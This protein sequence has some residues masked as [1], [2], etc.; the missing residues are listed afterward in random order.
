VTPSVVLDAVGE[1]SPTLDAY[2]HGWLPAVLPAAV[3]RVRV[4]D[5]ILASTLAD[6]GAELVD[7]APDVEIAPA[8]ELRGDA[9]LAVVTFDAPP[10]DSARLAVRLGRRLLRSARVRIEG[11]RAR[12]AVQSRGYPRADLVFWDVRQTFREPDL[13]AGSRSLVEYLPQRAL[14]LG[15]RATAAPT[16][17]EACL[18]DAAG[19]LGA[20]LRSEPPSIR[21]GLLTAVTDRGVLR[22]AV[23]PARGQIDAQVAALEALRRL[24]PPPEIDERVPWT[25]ADGRTGLARWSLE[26]RLAGT[27]PAA[28][29][30]P[31]LLARCVDFLVALQSCRGGKGGSLREAAATVARA[32]PSARSLPA[33]GERLDTV[34]AEVPRGFGHGDFFLGNLLLDERGA[35]SG[36]VDWD[37]AGSNRLPLIDLIHLRHM[38]EYSLPDEEWGPTLVRS[39]LPWARAGGDEAARA[40]CRRVGFDPDPW[41]VTALTL[42]YWLERLAYQ[43]RTHPHRHRDETWLER[44]IDHVLRSGVESEWT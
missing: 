28:G 6:A 30:T 8:D 15:K 27:R 35:V 5:P 26:R 22:V 3:R 14:V 9:L 40:F 42:G 20:P 18:A 29:L 13:R 41:Q 43:L 21:S 24:A 38:A 37:A 32:R 39:V 12:R 11:A 1:T 10:H 19:A 2:G 17:L 25:V 23:G 4:A 36:V 31:S 34:L 16:L 7:R 44:N 33:L